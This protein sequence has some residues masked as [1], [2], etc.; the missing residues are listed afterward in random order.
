MT[1]VSKWGNSLAVRIPKGVAEEM[2]LHDGDDVTMEFSRRGRELVMRKAPLP[3]TADQQA[4]AF[5]ALEAL[6]RRLQLDVAFDREEAN[7]MDRFDRH[8]R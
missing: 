8:G 6:R 1:Q 2:G 5:A 4:Q 3:S 7:G